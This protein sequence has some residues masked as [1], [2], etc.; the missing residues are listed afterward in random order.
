MV[1][2]RSMRGLR[3]AIQCRIKI[4]MYSDDTP[5]SGDIMIIHRWHQSKVIE[6]LKDI[7]QHIH[8]YDITTTYSAA[9]RGNNVTTLHIKQLSEVDG[10]IPAEFLTN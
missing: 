10:P 7:L 5:L 2:Y 1:Y 9:K 8:D 3:A 6:L 4:S